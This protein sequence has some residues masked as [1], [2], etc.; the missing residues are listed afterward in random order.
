[1]NKIPQL[2]SNEIIKALIRLGFEVIH[3][4]GSHVRM[5]H[6]DGRKVTVP[7]HNRPV[8]I[9]TIKSILSQAQITIEI[10]LENI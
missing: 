4:H 7:K 8:F 2:K 5:S 3:T 6:P 9:G 1:M 10:L